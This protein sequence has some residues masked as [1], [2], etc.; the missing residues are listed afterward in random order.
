MTN[1][2]FLFIIAFLA[3]STLFSC[4]E[5][6]PVRGSKSGN[7]FKPEMGFVPMEYGQSFDPNKEANIKKQIGQNAIKVEN[8]TMGP[9]LIRSWQ[10]QALKEI[11]TQ[12]KAS[13]NKSYA[14]LT[15][16]PFVID[17]VVV[18][19]FAEK[20]IHEGMWIR[21]K[22]DLTYEYGRYG[23]VKGKGRYYY[24]ADN[25]IITV[26]DDNLNVKPIEFGV[27]WDMGFIVIGGTKK[28]NDD[29]IMVKL[30]AKNE[31]PTK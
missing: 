8:F 24:N 28:Y 15:V 13:N 2:N 12:A 21:F 19:E 7:E 18:D 3:I 31:L 9:D 17:A 10:A 1:K 20:S 29:G 5:N 27:G 26:L 4:K 14:S 23:D 6:N 16:R 22:D 30:I 25:E 11:E